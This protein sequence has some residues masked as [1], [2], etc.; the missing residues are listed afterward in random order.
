MN[1]ADAFE[2]FFDNI[3]LKS[4][5]DYQTTIDE[6]FKKLNKYYYNLASSEEHGYVVGSIGRGTAVP[7]TSDVDLLFD[8]PSEVYSRFDGY[9]TNGQSAL[10]QEVKRVIKER[11]PR[12]DIRGDGQA[13]VIEFES[14]PFT[15]DLVPAFKQSDDSFKYP[16]TNKG[17]SWKKTN[18]IPEQDACSDAQFATGGWF[19]RIC[20]A[21][22]AWKDNEG[23]HFKGLLIDTLVNRYLED[24]GRLADKGFDASYSILCDIFEALSKE[25]PNQSFWYALGS[26]QKIYND[27]EG[28]FVSKASGAY[29]KLSEAVNSDEREEALRD[30]FGKKFSDC[31]VDS[32]VDARESKLAQSFGATSNEQFIEE[33]FPVDIRFAMELDCEVTQDGFRTDSLV[34]MLKRR[35]PLLPKKELKFNVSCCTVPEPYLLYWKV[36]NCGEEAYKRDCIRGQIIVGDRVWHEHTAFKGNH[37]VECYAIRNGICVARAKI[38]VPIVL[39]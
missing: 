15:V 2:T 11:Y 17:G 4:L 24:A 10:L 8:L 7:G 26:N 32:A 28:T 12:T 19:R 23:L 5:E 37:F 20:N 13:V 33:M 39:R 21:L 31:V 30:V 18:P 1:E 38:S 9:E 25:N 29:K 34:N 3:E 36:R 22:R 6:I 35:L 14:L 16:D 27:D